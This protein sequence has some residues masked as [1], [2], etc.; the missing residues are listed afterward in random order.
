VI[1]RMLGTLRGHPVL[2]ASLRAGGRV[3]GTLALLFFCLSP[4]YWMVITSLTPHNAIFS[5]DLLPATLSW[6][7][8][9]NMFAERSNFGLAIRNSTIIA[10][11][12]TVISM[13]IGMSAAYALVRFRLPGKNVIATSVLALAMFPGVVIVTPLFRVFSELN[14]IDHYQAMIV[15]DIGFALPLCIWMFIGFFT[16]LPWELEGAAMIDGCTRWQAFWWVM[17]P[18]LAPGVF[19]AAILIFVQAWSEYL[20]ASIMSQTLASE[21]VTVAV[22]HFPGD[23]E[24]QQ[25]FGSQMAAGVVVTI[26]LIFVIVLFQ[27]R[28][29]TGLTA[30]ALKG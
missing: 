7:N 18:L 9:R 20:V 3:L 4:I 19:T 5:N 27:R 30:G 13:V 11:S 6:E 24:F 1:A 10:T 17:C 25:P 29:V 16:E 26:P 2:R 21:P 22:A 23:S 14:W 15:P 12:V 28:I 8:Y